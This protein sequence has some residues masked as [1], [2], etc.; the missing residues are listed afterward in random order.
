MSG[1][2]TLRFSI[3]ACDTNVN[4]RGSINRVTVLSGASSPLTRARDDSADGAITSACPDSSAV[5]VHTEVTTV[6][7][8][9]TVHSSP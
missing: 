7:P 6:C 1:A 9:P 5:Y 2:P 3:P 8:P 4:L